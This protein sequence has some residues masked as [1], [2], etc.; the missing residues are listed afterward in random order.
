VDS[1]HQLVLATYALVLATALL[2]VATA[3]PA[4]QRWQ[5][6]RAA[7]RAKASRVVPDINILHSRL[8]GGMR[9]FIGM[10]EMTKEQA[11]RWLGRVEGEQEIAQE[12]IQHSYAISLKFANEM[13]LVRH[14]LTQIKIELKGIVQSYDRD[15]PE[16]E[17][18][19]R[20]DRLARIARLYKA[21]DATLRA[22]EDL[23]PREGRLVDGKSFW[24]RF[25]SVSE[26]RER[27]AEKELV[28]IR[29]TSNRPE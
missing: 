9:P 8:A 13:Y 20:R 23:L 5:D 4:I 14:F 7:R 17:H 10:V 25:A 2:V 19:V 21:G 15:N 24:D 1:E 3:I 28:D 12:I 6:E 22:A 26:T 18:D 16:D 11:E 27:S 29:A